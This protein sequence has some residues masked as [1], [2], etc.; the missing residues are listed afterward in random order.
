MSSVSASLDCA[1]PQAYH[2]VKRA[3]KS[4]TCRSNN[5]ATFLR[6]LPVS[7]MR[8]AQN[9]TI[10]VIRSL[11]A[12]LPLCRRHIYC[13]NTFLYSW[14]IFPRRTRVLIRLPFSTNLP[15]RLPP[16]GTANLATSTCLGTF[17]QANQEASR[18]FA[19][20]TSV[21]QMTPSTASTGS[22]SQVAS[23]ASR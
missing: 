4:L 22:F 5:N 23:Y 2:S 1:A 3:V 18:S 19:T 8:S 16:A 12:R 10:R 17:A 7:A 9:S 21:T 11:I 6:L 13:R 20:C 15:Y 14:P